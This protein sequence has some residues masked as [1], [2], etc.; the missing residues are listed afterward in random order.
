[1][2]YSIELFPEIYD[3]LQRRA[4]MLNAS[5]TAVVESAVRL[6]QR[7]IDSVPATQEEL[8]VGLVDELDQLAF[9]TD[10]ELWN[11]ARTRL[12]EEEQTRMEFLLGKQQ[13]SGLSSVEAAE[14]EALAAQYDRTMLV[15]AKAA[16]LLKER[17]HDIAILSP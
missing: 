10:A 7:G 12:R 1:M 2:S 5:L 6:Q 16:V 13:S 8:P 15:R 9:L 4:A 11:A 17:A 14:A 3:F